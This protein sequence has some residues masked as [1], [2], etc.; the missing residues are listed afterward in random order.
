VQLLD[1]HGNGSPLAFIGCKSSKP[2]KMPRPILGE[3]QPAGGLNNPQVLLNWFCPTSGVSR[4][5]FKIAFVDSDST[6]PPTGGFLS[7]QLHAYAGYNKS[8]GFLGL[9]KNVRQ[10]VSFSEAH[11]TPY[12]GPGFGPGPQFNLTANILP[13][14]TYDICVT[15]VDEQGVVR[16]EVTSEVFR[17]KWTPPT[18]L[19]T[20]P[21]PARPLPPVRNFDDV[22]PPASGPP[23]IAAVLMQN[24]NFALDAR[25]PVGVTIGDFSR[26]PPRDT[27]GVYPNA[28]TTNFLQYRMTVTPTIDPNEILV[29]RRSSNDP[30][31]NGQS[32]LPIILY[33]QQ[34]TNA[35]F[36][37]VS[38]D[39]TQVSPLVER[40]P[41]IS[42]NNVLATIPDRLIG[43]GFLFVNGSTYTT[44]CLRDQQPVIQGA[45]YRYFV[46]RFNNQHEAEE[47]IPAG[48]VE[49]PVN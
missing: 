42:A 43:S 39:V 47:I 29:Y 13:D 44:F 31:R 16:H 33:R 36:P 9:K 8:L 26:M 25:Y 27:S 35:M 46:M 14:T 5:Q 34:M 17:F 11:F 48:E 1:E 6:T 19:P 15:P 20:V 38:G 41:F 37:R 4:F 3:P 24:P 10:I 7:T 49:V 2:P 21:W 23:R 40:I 18:V 28:G 12:V 32:L 45:K 30:S 22:T